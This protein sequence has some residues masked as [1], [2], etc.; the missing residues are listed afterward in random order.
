MTFF[1]NLDSLRD[2]FRDVPCENIF[3]LSASAAGRFCEWVYI[4][5]DAYIPHRKY[6]VKRH[7]SPWFSAVC[8]AAI[9]H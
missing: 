1:A 5:T 7:S 8:A 9:V 3:K 4:G 2:H 6:Q